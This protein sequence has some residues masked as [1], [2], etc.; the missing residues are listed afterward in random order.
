MP[1]QSIMCDVFIE[2]RG[3]GNAGRKPGKEE[4][5]T[6]INTRTRKQEGKNSKECKHKHH[7]QPPFFAAIF[8][9][10]L[11]LPTGLVVRHASFSPSLPS[12]FS[13]RLNASELEGGVGPSRTEAA[14]DKNPSVYITFDF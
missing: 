3:N 4:S 7:H 6:I 5:D 13:H 14:T 2:G 12:P 9:C 8:L 11:S 10:L 1:P